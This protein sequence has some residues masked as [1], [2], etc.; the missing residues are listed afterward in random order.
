[1]PRF[2]QGVHSPG[3]RPL[4]PLLVFT[5]AH[6]LA[7]CGETCTYVTNSHHSIHG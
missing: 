5:F 1:M 3:K 7:T 6:G 4:P 2:P